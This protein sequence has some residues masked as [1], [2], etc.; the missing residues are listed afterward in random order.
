MLPRRSFD[1]LSCLPSSSWWTGWLAARMA[2][3]APPRSSRPAAAGGFVRSFW[4]PARSDGAIER[5]SATRSPRTRASFT[6]MREVMNGG[7][8]AFFYTLSNP[9]G[10]NT[11]RCEKKEERPNCEIGGSSERHTRGL[12]VR[13]KRKARDARRSVCGSNRIVTNISV[14]QTRETCTDGRENR[15]GRGGRGMF[16]DDAGKT[17]FPLRFV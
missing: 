12:G 6:W 11:K 5:T 3:L 16:S 17:F 14:Q 9:T 8:C 2:W 15:D 1:P 4:I 13:A 7:S 10:W